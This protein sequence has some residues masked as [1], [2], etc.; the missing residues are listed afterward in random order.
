MIPAEELQLADFA[1]RFPSRGEILDVDSLV[2]DQNHQIDHKS[3][4]NDIPPGATSCRV[5][6]HE[7]LKMYCPDPP[8]CTIPDNLKQYR[9]LKSLQAVFK[10]VPGIADCIFSHLYVAPEDVEYVLGKD[11]VSSMKEIQPSVSLIKD[12][13]QG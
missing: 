7:D 13:R 11:F 1:I 4:L 10:T 3:I 2:K 8:I 6:R 12:Y 5:Y 9:A